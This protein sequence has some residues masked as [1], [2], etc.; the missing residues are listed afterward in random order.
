MRLG[1]V[2]GGAAVAAESRGAT[3]SMIRKLSIKKFTTGMLAK[4][5]SSCA[6]CLSDYVDDEKVRFLPL[7]QLS[8]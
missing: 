2:A 4:D 3:D 6:I 5:D 8:I 1:D 7:I